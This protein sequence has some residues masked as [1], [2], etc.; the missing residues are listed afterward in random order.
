MLPALILD[1]INEY[2]VDLGLFFKNTLRKL[3]AW[4]YSEPYLPKLGDKFYPNKIKGK[5]RAHTLPDPFQY[6]LNTNDID[7]LD[8]VYLEQ[9]NSKIGW[10]TVAIFTVLAFGVSYYMYPDMYNNI[11]TFIIDYFF[12]PDPNGRGGVE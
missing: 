10:K 2:I 8:Y 7:D 3:I 6:T 5:N 11:Y 4:V 9:S 1:A 12:S